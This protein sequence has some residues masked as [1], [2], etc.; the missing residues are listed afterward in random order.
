MS[1]GRRKGRSSSTA[2]RRQR[3]H[4]S[5]QNATECIG[6]IVPGYG[7][8]AVTRGQFS[9][10][11][12]IL[13]CMDQVGPCRVSVW[14]WTIA[15]Y[16][17][18]VL[19]RMMVD[20]RILAG[21][22]VIDGGARTKNAD[23]ISHWRERFGQESVRYVMNHAK[24]ATVETDK[25]RLL[26]RGSMNLNFNPR[27]EQLDITEGGEDFTLIRSIED[28]LPVLHASTTGQKIYEASRV[29]EA[30]SMEQLEIFNGAKVFTL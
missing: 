11:D 24:I 21:R 10:I 27:F 8:F 5:F 30:F 20:R 25:Y 4:E 23:I 3:V 9:M 28:S 16:E 12:A 26:L 18:E 22:L 7:L 6:Q 2:V 15:D 1:L 29:G 17:V 19:T 14:T 13:A